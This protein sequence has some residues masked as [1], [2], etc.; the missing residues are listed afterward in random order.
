M[1][2]LKRLEASFDSEKQFGNI[3]A[4]VKSEV[5]SSANGKK[6]VSFF[7]GDKNLGTY[8]VNSFCN[9]NK[10]SPVRLNGEIVA[11]KD[12]EKIIAWLEDTM[13]TPTD[14]IQVLSY[15]E[16]EEDMFSFIRGKAY[17]ILKNG[18]FDWWL[19]ELFGSNFHRLDSYQALRSFISKFPEY[20]KE[21]KKNFPDLF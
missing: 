1:K 7:K 13:E 20:K 6:T 19:G 9:L 14:E 10:K 4:R 8:F 5:L 11:S 17:E 15:S 16:E 2:I 18:K 21:A 3:T 12:V